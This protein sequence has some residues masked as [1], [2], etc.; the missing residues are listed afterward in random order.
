MLARTT[1]YVLDGLEARRLIVDVDVRPGLPS[2]TLLRYNATEQR[3][4]HDTIR[5][6]L[7]ACGHEIPDTRVT[8]NV[9]PATVRAAPRGPLE[10]AVT[11]AL[12]K[13]SGQ[14]TGPLATRPLACYGRLTPRGEINQLPGI[15][16]AALTHDTPLLVSRQD[17]AAL[18]ALREITY[19]PC[20]SLDQVPAVTPHTSAG[21]A[22]ASVEHQNERISLHPDLLLA[23]TVAAGGRHSLMLHGGSA[24]QALEISRVTHLILPALTDQQLQDRQRISNAVGLPLHHPVRPPYRAP[25]PQITPAGLIGGGTPTRPGEITLAHHGILYL[26]D[27]PEHSRANLEALHVP[28]RDRHIIL[29]RGERAISYP[30]DAIVIAHN[31]GCICGQ[32]P[33]CCTAKDRQRLQAKLTPVSRWFPIHLN[34]DRLQPI[35]LPLELQPTVRELRARVADTRQRLASLP[36][37]TAQRPL[38]GDAGTPVAEL[39]RAG[40]INAAH[41]RT[42]AQVARTVAAIDAAPVTDPTLEVALSLQADVQCGRAAMLAHLHSL[43]TTPA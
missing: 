21:P 10:L 40:V 22:P 2:F 14:L 39:L 41:A 34:L 19:L 9:A 7:R 35:N 25:H 31:P 4:I 36:S 1:T 24:Q 20:A 23:L 43:T 30:A 26:T 6:A 28:L 33:C 37:D 11:L 3:Q 18:H 15:V 27:L 16:S 13:I 38:D 8:V 17:S 42:I 5:S 29:K 32:Q 12:L